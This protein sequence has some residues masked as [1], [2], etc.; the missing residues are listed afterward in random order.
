MWKYE[1][2]MKHY[3]TNSDVNELLIMFGLK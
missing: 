3:D 2:P 1:S